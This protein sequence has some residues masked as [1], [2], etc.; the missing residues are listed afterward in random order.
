VNGIEQHTRLTS[1]N[2][3]LTDLIAMAGSR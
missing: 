1:E 3:K 2:G